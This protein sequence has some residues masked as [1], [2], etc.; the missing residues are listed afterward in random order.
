MAGRC[1]ELKAR[2]YENRVPPE[3][4]AVH[5]W[6]HTWLG[7]VKDNVTVDVGPLIAVGPSREKHL[8]E[9]RRE[10][11]FTTEVALRTLELSSKW[12]PMATPR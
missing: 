10:A 11:A 6:S 9:F 7:A 8:P 1:R 12:P 2:D 5:H 3:A 4:Y